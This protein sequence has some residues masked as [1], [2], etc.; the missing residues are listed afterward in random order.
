MESTTTFIVRKALN[1][2]HDKYVRIFRRPARHLKLRGQIVCHG[3]VKY[4]FRL[5]GEENAIKQYL[6]FVSTAAPAL[7]PVSGIY[8]WVGD[9]LYTDEEALAQKPRNLTVVDDC[10]S[11]AVVPEHYI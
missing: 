7:G 4:H 8:L 6:A 9:D 10:H 5:D 11:D 1:I 2:P 3:G